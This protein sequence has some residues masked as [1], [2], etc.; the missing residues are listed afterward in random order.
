MRGMVEDPKLVA[1]TCVIEVEPTGHF[2]TYGVGVPLLA[3]RD[4]KKARGRVSVV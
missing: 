4:S 1:E 2:V 3:M